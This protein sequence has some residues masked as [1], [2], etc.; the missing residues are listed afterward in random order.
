MATPRRN[1]C[2][3]FS[4]KPWDLPEDVA[5]QTYFSGYIFLHRNILKRPHV[6]VRGD[7]TD[8]KLY[9]LRIADFLYIFY[10]EQFDDL[11]KKKIE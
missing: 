3:R 5:L 2:L 1:T 10:I 6:F 8:V 9:S 7:L 11:V 4:N